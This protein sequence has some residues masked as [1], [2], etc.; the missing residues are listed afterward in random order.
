MAASSKGTT[1]TRA[2]SWF[3]TPQESVLV[4]TV[5]AKPH[6][7]T[8]ALDWL[9]RRGDK[10]R[11]LR[12]IILGAGNAGLEASV[13][14]I[15]DE[16]RNYPDYGMPVVRVPVRRMMPPPGGSGMW[17][18]RGKPIGTSSE[19]GAA[20]AVWLT[21]HGLFDEI[22]RGETRIDLLLSG[23]PRLASLL[24]QTVA[25]LTFGAQ[26]RIWHMNSS[27]DLRETAS[28][29]KVLHAQH[30]D[31]VRMIP[32]PLPP[33]GMLFPHLRRAAMLQPAEI[34][35]GA[36]VR[37]DLMEEVRCREVLGR[38]APAEL[39]VLRA[40]AQAPGRMSRKAL[41]RDLN[42]SENTIKTHLGH[43]YEEVS[44]AWSGST[45]GEAELAR[46]KF[47][48]WPDAEWPPG[49]EG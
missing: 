24:G 29:Q 9:I 4:A 46:E 10:P 26:D 11:E 25:A 38:L 31:E 43:I 33:M 28:S 35:S 44:I 49:S 1:G 2:S 5:G 39:R 36:D 20:D 41:A 18:P 34:L 15:E 6:V 14:R 42:L 37:L 47:R 12:L 40:L 8:L 13:A 27:D 21:W 30:P 19:P 23:G 3:S 16:C 22:K 17:E 7:V 32:V 48:R 45:L